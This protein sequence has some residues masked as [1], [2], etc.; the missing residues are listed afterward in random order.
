MLFVYFNHT[1]HIIIFEE[2]I[3]L[4]QNF[5]YNKPMRLAQCYVP[6]QQFENIY[7]AAD[8]LKYGTVFADLDVAAKQSYTPNSVNGG[9][10]NASSN[11]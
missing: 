10:M 3:K 8:A 5:T 4:M 1:L 2:S 9:I 7:S 6:V 11:N